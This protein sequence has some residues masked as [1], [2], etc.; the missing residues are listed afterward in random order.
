MLVATYAEQD[1]LHHPNRR[2]A[3]VIARLAA[4]RAVL[5]AYLSLDH[6][7]VFALREGRAIALDLEWDLNYASRLDRSEANLCRLVRSNLSELI[8]HNR[9]EWL[10]IDDANDHDGSPEPAAQET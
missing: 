2:A 7:W 3:F 1:K 6:A 5:A 9:C 4:L 8:A 10:P